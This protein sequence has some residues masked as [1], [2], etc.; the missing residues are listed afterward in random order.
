MLTIYIST[1]TH[2]TYGVHNFLEIRGY[3]IIRARLVFDK[4][5][6]FY[7]MAKT[8]RIFT[9]PVLFINYADITTFFTAW[10]HIIMANTITFPLFYSFTVW[11][12]LW[13]TITA[14]IRSTYL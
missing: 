7:F 3:Y 11:K 10:V 1:A 13:M 12:L 6:W 2:T 5:T 14:L 9:S 4:F 8:F